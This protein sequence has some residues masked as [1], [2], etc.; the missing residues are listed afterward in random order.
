LEKR[1]ISKVGR[2]ALIQA[3]IESM[4]AHIMQCFQLPKK[5]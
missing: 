2:V 5:N 3:N 1:H 4:P